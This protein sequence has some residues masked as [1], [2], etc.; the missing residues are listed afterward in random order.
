[1]T[2]IECLKTRS[3]TPCCESPGEG[4]I[5]PMDL[6][7]LSPRSISTFLWQSRLGKSAEI[8][9]TDLELDMVKCFQIRVAGYEFDGYDDMDW[10]KGLVIFSTTAHIS[11]MG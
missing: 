4:F 1:M 3:W 11:R 2:R 6:K 5:L 7:P 8:W 9:N 10:N